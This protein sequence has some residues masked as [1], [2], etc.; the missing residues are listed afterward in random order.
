MPFPSPRRGALPSSHASFRF[1]DIFSKKEMS[2]L[3]L[4]HFMCNC[5]TFVP[6]CQPFWRCFLSIMTHEL[7]ILP[8]AQIQG[9]LFGH[10]HNSY[11]V[12]FFPMSHIFI[13][14]TFETVPPNQ[15]QT[16]NKKEPTRRRRKRL[17]RQFLHIFIKMYKISPLF[18]ER[19]TDSFVPRRAMVQW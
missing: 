8:F 16:D 7:I 5:N 2:W 19:R 13:G 15:I 10:F 12:R 4:D 1:F 17:C 6:R 11:F 3:F 14:D 9:V 18:A